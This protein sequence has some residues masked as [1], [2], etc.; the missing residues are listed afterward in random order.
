MTSRQPEITPERP[1]YA[2]IPEDGRMRGDR[3]DAGARR[4]PVSARR[5]PVLVLPLTLLII[6]G[7]AGLRGQMTGPLW[8]GPLHDDPVA[9]GGTLEAALAVML[10]V[11]LRRL[12]TG[13]P[14]GTAEAAS[15]DA[16][17]VKLRRLLVFVLGAGMVAVAATLLVGVHQHLFAGP[18]R[19]R[20]GQGA[21]GAVPAPAAGGTEHLSFPHLHVHVPFVLLYVLLIVIFAGLVAVRVWWVRS[22]RRSPPL[23]TYK[24]LGRDSQDLR[25][26]LESGRSA[27]YAIDEARAAIIACYLAMETSLAERGAAR[28]IADTPDEL[29]SRATAT[30]IVRGTAAGQLTALFYE[31]RFSSHSLDAGQREQAGQALAELAAVLGQA[32]PDGARARRRR[33]R[34]RTSRGR[35]SQSGARA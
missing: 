5:W 14:A 31:A 32:E 15:S 7:L 23:R 11:T 22:L 16:V 30:G 27:L 20:S 19:A 1:A 33:S 34:S 28:A 17:P 26:A 35:A 25:E 4:R 10:A 6:A 2:A 3:D 12:V 29:L 18:A 21:S 24:Y 8:D 9:V 13:P